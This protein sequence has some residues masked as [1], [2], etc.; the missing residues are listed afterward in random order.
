MTIGSTLQNSNGKLPAADAPRSLWVATAIRWRYSWADIQSIL[1]NESDMRLSTIFV[2]A[3]IH[4]AFCSATFACSPA[5]VCEHVKW[6]ATDG[7]PRN[8]LNRTELRKSI[9]RGETSNIWGLTERCQHD[10]G[11]D[12]QG[13]R[14]VQE[15]CPDPVYSKIAEALNSNGITSCAKRQRFYCY[16]Q[17]K[18]YE[19]DHLGPP[20]TGV[21]RGTPRGG[22]TCAC[23]ESPGTVKEGSP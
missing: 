22:A 14:V 6:C 2:A 11:S 18:Y 16:T 13:W 4:F 1:L 3:L 9:G 23:G 21:C 15:G 20:G 19:L 10:V 12:Y 17:G 5:D 8:E 7:G